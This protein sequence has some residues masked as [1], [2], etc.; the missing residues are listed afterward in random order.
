MQEQ[1]PVFD[2]MHLLKV[3]HPDKS[4][5]ELQQWLLRHA[6]VQHRNVQPV[7][8]CRL[9]CTG[10]CCRWLLVVLVALHSVTCF[11]L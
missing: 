4:F 1:K 10:V 6:V 11:V 2:V 9:L 8:L 5:T 3:L 7:R